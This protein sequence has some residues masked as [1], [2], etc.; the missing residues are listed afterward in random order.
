[1]VI[2]KEELGTIVKRVVLYC[3]RRKA[4][5]EEQ[6]RVL[7]M[8]PEYPVGLKKVIAEY[9]LYGEDD[10]VDFLFDHKFPEIA[11]MKCGRSF[12]K[13]NEKDVSFVFSELLEYE[14]IEVY[15]PSIDFLRQIKEGHEENLMVRIAL[16]FLMNGN[17]VTVRLPYR[18]ENLPG[19]RFTKAMKDL[20]DDLW[21]M[22]ITFSELMP[23]FG[24][25]AE[26]KTGIATGLIT[27]EVIEEYHRRG[28]ERIKI[29]PGCIVT[30]LGA[31]RA[32]DHNMQLVKGAV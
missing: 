31:E 22:G 16:Y 3:L 28:I 2:S 13:D 5:Q 27:E 18:A 21:D 4:M 17:N 8:V 10:R 12:Y 23:G 9:Q 14:E 1:M 6:G 29:L 26:I 25:E 24:S 20:L 32:K 19:G 30:P 7:F 15:A 11:E